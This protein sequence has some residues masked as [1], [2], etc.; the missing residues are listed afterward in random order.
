MH[1]GRNA[2]S[3][4]E[5]AAAHLRA[6][7][8]ATRRGRDSLP[9]LRAKE[10]AILRDWAKAQSC[11]LDQDPT[12]TLERRSAHGEHVVGFDPAHSCWWKITHPGKA[13]VGAEFQ[14]EMLPPFSIN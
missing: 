4:L 8:A 11:L 7:M 14:Y 6:G 9:E 5:N 10:R 12:L 2:T 13:G 1:P 3:S